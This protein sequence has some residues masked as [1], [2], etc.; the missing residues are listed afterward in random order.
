MTREQVVARALSAVGQGCAYTLGTGGANPLRTVPWGDD[1]KVSDCSG[2][3]CW[4]LGIHRMIWL[5]TFRMHW[6]AVG[7][8][9]LREV[10]WLEAKPGDLLVWPDRIIEGIKHEGHV[11]VV[12]QVGPAGASR[13]THC[14]AGNWRASG[15]AIQETGVEKFVEAKAIVGRPTMIEEA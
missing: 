2:F 7:H 3:A 15:D 13:V 14:S 10:G 9:P 12:T 8:T 4:A 6:F 5:D 1:K 11:G